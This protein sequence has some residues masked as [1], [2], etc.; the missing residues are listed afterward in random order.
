M[1]KTDKGDVTIG[2]NTSTILADF[3]VIVQTLHDDAH[4][5][6]EML[7]RAFERSFKTKEEVE[8]DIRADIDKI[9]EKDPAKA[10]ICEGL[11]ELV[12]SLKKEETKSDD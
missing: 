4:I 12:K 11:F 1:I 6:K 5:S 9:R 10:K 3:V 8:K 2:G 7:R